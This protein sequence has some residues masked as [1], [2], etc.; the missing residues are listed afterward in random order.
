MK[1]KKNITTWTTIMLLLL[2]FILAGC[3]GSGGTATTPAP[4]PTASTLSGVAAAGAPVIGTVTIKDNSSPTK[5]EKTVTIAADGKYTVD[6]SDMTAPF[7]MRADGYVGG[8]EYHL[9]S[10][11]TPAD[12]GGTVN[13]TPFTD[14]IVA[15]IAGDIA[16][17][18]FNNGSYAALTKADLDAAQASL[19][20]KLQPVLAAVGLGDSIDLMR[21][22]FSADHK[23]LDGVLDVLKVTVDPTTKTAEIKN[24]INNA[25]ISDDLKSKADTSAF[26]T[27]QAAGVA[28]GLTDVQAIAKGFDDFSAL[29]ATSLPRSDNAQLLAMF[30]Q[31]GFMEDGQ[32]LAAFLGEIT[33][34]PSIIGLKFSNV[35]V[36]SL[37]PV[38]GTGEVAFVPIVQGRAQVEGT[39]RF[40]MVKKNNAWLMQGNQKIAY[41]EIEVQS[42]LSYNSGSATPQIQTGLHLNIRDQGAKGIAKAVVTGPGLP[43]TGITLIKD[44]A[45]SQFTIQ[46]PIVNTGGGWFPMEEATIAAMPETGATYSIELRD[47]A[48]VL[49]TTYTYTIKKRPYKPSELTTASFPA[50]TAP[51]LTAWRAFTGGSLSVTWT[52]PAGLQAD[53]MSVFLSGTGGSSQAEK[54]L[55]PTATTTTL[56]IQPQDSTGTTFTI[57]GRN[58]EVSVVDS[59]GRYLRT[60]LQN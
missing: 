36:V 20:T 51:T 59:F 4:T 34:D 30:D 57:T 1:N 8:R 49:M 37:D 2:L 5:K 15:N 14:L 6:V 47:A 9:Y 55:A 13:I 31:A 52:I 54:T 48:N 21:T 28:T 40:K 23:G 56:T 24:I 22:A 41:T 7:A 29:F 32:N 33:I 45:S 35:S 38:A 60:H 46:A 16:A 12:V 17:N 39:N 42:Q 26:T 27:Q 10:A 44:I 53:F 50:I 25:A 18:Y 19:K 11:A 58:L 3:G 43:S